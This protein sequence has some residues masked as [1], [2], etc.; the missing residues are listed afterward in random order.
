MDKFASKNVLRGRTLALIPARGGSKGILQKNIRNF[1]G[2]PLIAYTISQ[3]R[4]LKKYIDRVVISTDDPKI[5]AVAKRYGAEVPFLRPKKFSGD[6][7]PVIDAVLYTL[8]R[9]EREEGYRPE[10]VL[11]LQTTSPLRTKK[12]II[13]HFFAMD[14]KT[15]DAVLTVCPTH[16]LLFHLGPKNKLIL[17]NR[18]VSRRPDNARQLFLPGFKLNGC[19]AYLIK[20]DTLFRERTFFPKRTR[21]VVADAWRSIDLDHPEDF[22]LV[23]LIYKNLSKLAAKI[24]NFH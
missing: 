7:S 3:A 9:L 21:A 4:S 18:R 14:P 20:R 1:C 17:A 10:Y 19:F 6:K 13:A 11:L 16:H 24:K 15:T 5:A 23:E 8:S 12:D 2:K 22:L